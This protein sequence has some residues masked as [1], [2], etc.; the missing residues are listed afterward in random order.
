M[1][2]Q[3]LR[4]IVAVDLSEAL[5]NLKEKYKN[6]SHNFDGD[7]IVCEVTEWRSPRHCFTA[8]ASCLTDDHE[9]KGYSSGRFATIYRSRKFRTRVEAEAH[10]EVEIRRATK[11]HPDSRFY[12]AKTIIYL[13]QE[14]QAWEV[15][16]ASEWSDCD[17]PFS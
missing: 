3:M 7:N 10:L 8:G 1:I 15:C 17:Y 11:Y 6:S 2:K 14:C 5:S 12:R 13:G 16:Q 4:Y 9:L